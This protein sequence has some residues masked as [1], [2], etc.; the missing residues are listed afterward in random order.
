M[1]ARVEQARQ[2]G[3][4]R[5]GLAYTNLGPF[6]QTLCALANGLNQCPSRQVQFHPEAAAFARNNGINPLDVDGLLA[7]IRQRTAEQQAALLQVATEGGY[8]QAHRVYIT[9]NR[10]VSTSKVPPV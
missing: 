10:D 1:L 3:A 5:P 2:A 8:L 7:L 6:R 4:H 9:S